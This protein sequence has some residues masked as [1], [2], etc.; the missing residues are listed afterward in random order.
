MAG[1]ALLGF[2]AV[3]WLV[4]PRLETQ[5]GAL[6]G[7][8]VSI[9]EL[10]TNPFTLS[11]TVEGFAIAESGTEPFVEVD[12]LFADFEL[13]SLVRGAFV[14]RE[15]ALDGPRL[16]ITRDAG[17]E[18]DVLRVLA[19][20]SAASG[21]DDAEAPSPPP[22]EPSERSGPP[23]PP[24]SIVVQAL[25]LQDGAITLRDAGTAPPFETELAP[26]QFRLVD[27]STLPD[28]GGDY[29]LQAESEAGERFSWSGG[30]TMQPLVATGSVAVEQLAL[31]KYRPYLSQVLPMRYTRG[32][33][34]AAVRY[35]VGF[36]EAGRLFAEVADGRVAVQ[37]AAIRL[38]DQQD[39][40]LGVGRFE[41][42][43]FAFAFP[44]LTGDVDRIAVADGEF[45]VVVEADGQTNLDPL[46]KLVEA[47]A[48]SPADAR[49]PAVPAPMAPTSSTT[50]P[51]RPAQTATAAQVADGA[52]STPDL[53]ALRFRVGQ[54]RV[55]RFALNSLH[56]TGAGDVPANVVV[57]EL[58]VS[59][60]SL[61]ITQSSTVG[62]QLD[63]QLLETGSL[64]LS[65]EVGL[66]PP[67]ARARLGLVDFPL[68]PLQPYV[69]P[70]ARLQVKS[71]R[72]SVEGRVEAQWDGELRAS[73]EG[74]SRVDDLRTIDPVGGTDF[75]KWT[76][77]GLE[78]ISF[79]LTPPA[80]TVRAVQIDAPYARVLIREDLSSNIGD[81]F[82]NG[83]VS[84]G[85]SEAD[86]SS[87]PPGQ[88]DIR[89]GVVRVRDGSINFADL[90][91]SPRFVAGIQALQGRIEELATTALGRGNVELRGRVDRY[92]PVIIRGQLRPFSE[93]S[94]SSISLDFRNM[95]MTT[96]TPYAA[97][98][99][100]HTI[101]K[102]KLDV[103]LEYTVR[104]PEIEGHN[105]VVIDQLTL[106]D[107]VE[108]PEAVKLPV[109]LAVALLK[110][111]DGKI[112]IDLPV[113]GRLDDPEFKVGPVVWKAVLNLMEKAVLSPFAAI[114]GLFSARG[115]QAEVA[116]LV[117]T[118]TTAPEVAADLARLEAALLE[119]SALVL[120]IDGR[121]S[122]EDKDALAD[123]ALDAL[124]TELSLRADVPG[125]DLPAG[126]PGDNLVREAHRRTF[127]DGVATSTSVPLRSLML[128]PWTGSA[129]SPE[130][131]PAWFSEPVEAL[132]G[133]L[134]DRIAVPGDELR[135]LAIQRAEAVRDA[136]LRAGR[137]APERVFV[138]E[139]EPSDT[140]SVTLRLDA[141]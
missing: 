52:A 81:V 45:R 46:L 28:G 92:A 9:A 126:D 67:R 14:F 23:E 79:S 121:W 97:R 31:P 33:L 82:A 125:P 54:L 68:A 66:D 1:Y 98:F 65:S 85:P 89:V 12:R 124:L 37:D 78:G 84:P 88:M 17:G 80:L 22:S 128:R 64:E 90:S 71:G 103:K 21:A 77:L 102:G 108:S 69:T 40:L 107:R 70:F 96:L 39:D 135:T 6:T 72:L 13:S 58:D 25:E 95:E 119:K 116:F 34:D 139:P 50:P 16:R 129:P 73:F 61:P 127:A 133:A 36:D 106:G 3:P 114:G 49:A 35:R 11:A 60:F 24:V 118:S 20:V 109:K 137:V 130:A 120:E 86:A 87:A 51:P 123:Q 41:I 48:P 132:R 117:G 59:G 8:E 74:T 26:I 32:R 94:P 131:P 4:R 29:R 5:L 15:L 10:A 91:V 75:V 99:A 56:R 27:F 19:R 62:V 134:A 57:R 110:D 53:G 115:E 30:A 100:G 38:G 7:C 83:Q 18:V 93:G 42:A 76:S 63:V 136:V 44:A 112:E 101:E 111:K 105:D 113:R 47:D 138:L 43:G 140:P 122:D 2:F 141:R 55:E 104:G